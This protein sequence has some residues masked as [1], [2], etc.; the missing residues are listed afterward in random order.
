MAQLNILWGSAGN[1][2]TSLYL[3]HLGELQTGKEGGDIESE[4]IM[5]SNSI[6]SVLFRSVVVRSLVPVAAAVT[7][8]RGGHWK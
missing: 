2:F 7:E 5:F 8:P 6:V 1:V 3:Q 4:L